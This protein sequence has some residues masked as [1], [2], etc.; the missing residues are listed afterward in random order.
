MRR[1]L[2]LLLCFALCACA[3]PPQP[4]N[5]ALWQI[6]GP[7]GRQGWL[8]GT[9]HALDR[10]ADWRGAAVSAAL[11]DAGTI[12]VE[13]ADISDQAAMGETFAELATSPGQP[14]LSQ[15][16]A[17]PLR[18]KLAQILDRHGL[19]DNQFAE[20]ESW[21]AALMIA[22]AETAEM[23][24]RN[25]V[26][27][28]VLAF[29]GDRPVIELEGARGQLALFDGL[30]EKEQRDLLAAV[31]TDAGN[32]RDDEH[33]LARA[34]LAGDMKRITRETERGMLADPELRAALFTGRNERWAARIAR[35]LDNG[36]R[37]FVAVGAAHMAGPDGL[38]AQ[39]ADLGYTVKRVQ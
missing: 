5:P 26:D 34:W 2:S 9:I 31:V 20:T 24:S 35:A 10:P 16:I 17:P 30:P 27:R 23:D 32:V 15:R 6:E 28:A 8:F 33:A 12:I 37:P 18:G 39:L 22:Q 11:D 38:P 36:K 13:V 4:A 21:A 29:A 25:G 3:Q 7:R 14:A 1:F 19:S